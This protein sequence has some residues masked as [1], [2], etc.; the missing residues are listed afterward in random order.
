M[1]GIS[2][3]IATIILVVITISLTGTAYLFFSGTLSGYTSGTI[4]LIYAEGYMVTIQNSGTGP[5]NANS[6]RILVNGEDAEIANPQTI[7][8]SEIKILKFVPINFSTELISARILIVGPSNS[9][10]YTTSMIPHESNVISE[11]VDLSH[12]NSVNASNYVLDESGYH[13]DG[14]LT[15]MNPATDLVNGRFG[16]A[17]DFDG[18]DDYVNI[19]DSSS[20]DITD[21]ITIEAWV[22]PAS[23]PWPSPSP[24]I[25]SKEYSI[26][27]RPYALELVNSSRTVSF[28]L[29][30]TITYPN[31][32]CTNAPTNSIES[33]KWSHVVGT[34]NGTV[35]KIYVN[36]ELK[37]SVPLTGTL[38]I[39]NYHVLIGNNRPRTRQFAGIIDEVHILN[40]A[41]TQEEILDSIY[42]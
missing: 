34:W 7:G 31:E 16:L 2:T 14:L 17:L 15:N 42:G 24:R 10:S 19:T 9:L 39:T 25:V 29:N 12:F 21:A 40:R 30:T 18:I 20:L 1:K 32:V 4:G 36:G 28:C 22:Y 6:I 37:N 8:P 26:T 35:V 13:N 11:T 38:F 33:N 23:W 3:I 5:I 41:L 27:A